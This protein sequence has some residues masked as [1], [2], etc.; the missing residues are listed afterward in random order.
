MSKTIN[1]KRERD[2]GAIITDTFGFIR[3]QWKPFFITIFKILWPFVAVTAF[4]MGM[5]LYS[6][7][8]MF[9]NLKNMSNSSSPFAM[10]GGDF[11]LWISLLMI[12][13]LVT[14]TLLH[15]AAMFYIKAYIDDATNIDFSSISKQVKTKFW[16][17]LGFFFLSYLLIIIALM[18]CFFPGIYIMYVFA[19]GVPI[20]IFE[21]KGVGETIEY[22]FTLIKTKWWET[23]GVLLVVGLLVGILGYIFN[24]PAMIYSIIKM[25]GLIKDNDPTAMT[26]LMSDP[27]YLILT[28]ISYAGRFLLS[29]ISIVATVFVYFDLNEQKFHSGTI[30]TIESLGSN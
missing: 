22:C 28:I 8:N 27:I 6:F 7:S 13:V 18:L 16:S 25:I 9:S 19:L 30:E 10:Y 2:L 5:Y 21:D 29:A 3:T 17:L 15:L 11:F 1:F 24:I 14:Y 26:G 4:F 12:S 23:F 20:L